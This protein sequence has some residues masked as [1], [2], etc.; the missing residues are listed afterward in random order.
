MA[1]VM[2]KSTETTEGESINP[3]IDNA[4]MDPPR[5]LFLK[6]TCMNVSCTSPGVGLLASMEIL[7]KLSRTI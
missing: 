2:L 7:G 4:A 1:Q 6:Y 3:A 5:N